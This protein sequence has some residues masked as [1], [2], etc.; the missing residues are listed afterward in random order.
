VDGRCDLQ[1]DDLAAQALGGQA[2]ARLA[3]ARAAPLLLQRRLQR[4]DLCRDRIRP[5]LLARVGWKP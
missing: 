1:L 4:L 2:A 3:R 5:G